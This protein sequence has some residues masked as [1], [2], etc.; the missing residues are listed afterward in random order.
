M[1]NM[2]Y[3]YSSLLAVILSTITFAQGSI[4]Y[5]KIYSADNG[6]YEVLVTVDVYELPH[7][8]E[9]WDDG[10]A[11]VQFWFDYSMDLIGAGAPSNLWT[12]NGYATCQDKTFYLGNLP[13]SPNSASLRNSNTA[14]I[15]DE[16]A[17]PVMPCFCEN[18][19]VYFEVHGP[20]L[21]TT[22]IVLEPSS[23]AV[24]PIELL[25]FEAIAV[26]RSIDLEWATASETNNEFFTIERSNDGQTWEEIAYIDGA[27]NSSNQIDYSWTDNTPLNGVSYYRLKQTDFDGEF[28]YSE[29]AAVE[30]NGKNEI[31]VYPNPAKSSVTI[32]F[33]KHKNIDEVLFL[34][35]VG[36]NVSSRVTILSQ[37][38]NSYL[39]D[40]S[41][42]PTGFYFVSYGDQNTRLVKE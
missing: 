39:I 40:I 21:N 4:F 32:S 41:G 8:Y 42:L 38:E 27:G 26:G 18:F 14:T 9:P 5:S 31:K 35:N 37:S 33:D 1:I 17:E 28:S 16:C 36:R 6:A 20:N 29:I 3:I 25:S 2:N 13:N 12:F 30:L 10:T 34:D 22:T 15:V 11:N 7:T 19:E 23:F 24:L